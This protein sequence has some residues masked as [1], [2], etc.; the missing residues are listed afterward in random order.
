MSQSGATSEHEENYFDSRLMRDKAMWS[1]WWWAVLNY[2][3]RW[4]WCRT[5]STI[6]PTSA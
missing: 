1:A 5:F 2:F 6:R 4:N 3:A